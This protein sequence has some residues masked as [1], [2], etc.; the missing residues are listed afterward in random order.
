MRALLIILGVTLI[1]CTHTLKFRSSPFLSPIVD[2]KSLSGHFGVVASTPTTVTIINDIAANPP[3]RSEVKI[4]EDYDLGDI[5]LLS[6]IGFDLSLSL[7]G[8]VE[9]YASNS[10]SGLKWQ[11]LNP[12]G[13]SEVFV[14]A[15]RA[16]VGSNS[17]TTSTSSGGVESSAK[18]NIAN[19]E[20]GISVGY[21]VRPTFI[22]YVSYVEDSYKAETSVNNSSG[23]FSG[24]EDA[25]K[26]STL[27]VGIANGAPGFDFGIEY[28]MINIK[29][30]R[31]ANS[32][33][34]TLGLKAGVRW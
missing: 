2:E 1:S 34:N 20:K 33:Q 25:G 9:V 13:K 5:L 11:F 30:D 28:N 24:Y 21:I 12:G 31:S 27:S 3:T 32:Y 18:S 22:P 8:S 17:T 10:S 4:N 19:Q 29:W 15:L 23:G 6:H 7:L 16:G 14:A 26:H